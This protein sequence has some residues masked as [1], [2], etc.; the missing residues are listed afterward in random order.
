MLALVGVTGVLQRGPRQDDPAT[1]VPYGPFLVPRSLVLSTIP[2]VPTHRSQF[3]IRNSPFEIFSRFFSA[4][5]LAQSLERQRVH[6]FKADIT[7]SEIITAVACVG[8]AGFS[9]DDGPETNAQVNSP[10]GI[11]ADAV[12]KLFIAG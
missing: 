8:T 6:P 7:G 3:T 5:A 11:P 12:G 10:N 1:L 9:R 2:P 4:L